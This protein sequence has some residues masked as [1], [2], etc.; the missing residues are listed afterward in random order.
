[1]FG[2]HELTDAQLQSWGYKDKEFQFYAF[3]QPPGD[4]RLY[5]AVNRWINAKPQGDPCRDFTLTVAETEHPD[6]RL[7]SWGYTE[8]RIQFYVPR[9]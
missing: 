8:K 5:M 3:R 9:P 6:S 1:M 7:Q 2:E 4:G